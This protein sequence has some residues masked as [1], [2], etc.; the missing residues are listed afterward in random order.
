MTRFVFQSAALLCF[1]LIGLAHVPAAAQVAPDAGRVLQEELKQLPTPPRTSKGLDM[2]PTQSAPAQPG[3]PQVVVGSITFSGNTVFGSDELLRVLGKVQDQ[4]FDLVGLRSLSDKITQHYQQA[5]YPFARAFIAPQQLVNG[6]ALQIQVVEGRYGRVSADGNP[7]LTQKAQSY[8]SG[9]QSGSLIESSALERTTLL[10]DDLPGIKITPVIRPGTALGT[11]DLDIVVD[12][13]KRY[14]GEVGLDNHGNYYSGQWRTRANLDINSPF[15][16]GDQISLRALYTQSHLWL[17]SAN[18]SIPL[19]GQGLRA[20]IGYAQTVY[21]LDNGFEGNEGVARI[22][23]AGLGYALL[24][25]QRSNIN[26]SVS[27]Q[28]KRLYNS[29]FFGASTER[30][31]STTLPVTLGFDH[32]DSFGGGGVTYGAVTWTQGHLHKDDVVRQGSFSKYNLDL[33]RLQA[34]TGNVSLFVRFSGQWANKNLDSSESMSL[35]G[36]SAVR[37]YPSGEASGDQGWLTQLELRYR[38]GD[39]SPYAFYDYG[40]MKINARP[41]QVTSPA[42]DETRAGAGVGVRYQA[43]GLSMDAAIAWRTRGGEPSSDTHADPKPR[44]W[45]TMAYAF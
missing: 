19:G 17:G 32:K 36:A 12:Y 24:R 45:L 5:S 4:S 29:Y 2:Q 41:S 3:G 11:G 39:F 1:S 30:Y 26:L 40:Y 35:G 44:F 27:W 23:G 38:L 8:L 18:Y 10:L 14:Q 9:L 25:S 28:H 43:H 31:H 7:G 34:V 33:V 22:S 6:G 21:S 20:N 42:P 15:A 37:A 13:D 16:L